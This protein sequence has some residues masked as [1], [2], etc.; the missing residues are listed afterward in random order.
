[1]S[2]KQSLLNFRSTANVFEDEEVRNRVFDLMRKFG[3]KGPLVSYDLEDSR[4][5][6]FFFMGEDG[7]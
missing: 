4:G 6:F 3:S 7:G 2:V 1:M 5:F